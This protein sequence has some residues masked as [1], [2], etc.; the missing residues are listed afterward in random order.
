MATLKQTVILLSGIPATRKSTFARY[1]ASEHGFAHYNLECDPRDWP[2]PELKAKWDDDR[3][4]FVAELRKYHDRVVLDWGF[5]V[6]CSS[7]ISEL[8]DQGVRLV[9]FDGDVT[10]AREAFIKRGG[11]SPEY[12][13]RQVE[14]IKRASYPDSLDCVIVPSLSVDGIF[15]DSRQIERIVFASF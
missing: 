5:P 9:W 10:R 6:S 15:L 4:A 13:D 11:I 12:F 2:H 14:A 8:I 1:L 7:W 3:T